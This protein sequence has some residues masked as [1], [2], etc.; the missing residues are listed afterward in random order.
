MERLLADVTDLDRLSLNGT[1]VTDAIIPAL[2]RLDLAVLDL[3][4]TAVTDA[5]LARFREDRPGVRL[6]PYVPPPGYV[7]P[8]SGYE[9]ARL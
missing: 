1:P 9:H 5:A 7:P 6:H 2:N 8:P 3:R 4:R